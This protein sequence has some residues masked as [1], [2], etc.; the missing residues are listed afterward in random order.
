MNKF[1][2]LWLKNLFEFM[3]VTNARIDMVN[4]PTLQN[5]KKSKP[6]YLKTTWPMTSQQKSKHDACA[7]VG[8][9]SASVSIDVYTNQ[10]QLIYNKEWNGVIK[11]ESKWKKNQ[12]LCK[13]WRKQNSVFNGIRVGDGILA[14]PI[15]CCRYRQHG[16]EIH[17][18]NGLH[19]RSKPSSCISWI[20]KLYPLLFE[21]YNCFVS[22]HI[23]ECFFSEFGDNCFLWSQ[24]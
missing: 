22:G 2:S 16:P 21:G 20:E 11:L 23:Q 5:R 12:K 8:Q 19:W 10:Q 17:I 24:I 13:E 3:T 18:T 4:V 6:E 7:P 15:Q 14:R 1:Q 9:N